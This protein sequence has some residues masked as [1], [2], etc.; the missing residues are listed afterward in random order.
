VFVTLFLCIVNSF[1]ETIVI[2]ASWTQCR[3]PLLDNIA[4][5]P[6]APSPNWDHTCRTS[7]SVDVHIEDE[8]EPY[9]TA[10]AEDSDDDCP[11]Q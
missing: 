5:L 10:R 6:L 11:I 2:F 8:E 7:N 1:V 3:G 4:Y 9:E